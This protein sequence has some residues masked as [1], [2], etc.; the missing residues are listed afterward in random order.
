ML[1]G[2]E[3]AT[4]SI[5]IFTKERYKVAASFPYYPLNIVILNKPFRSERWN[6]EV[7]DLFIESVSKANFPQEYRLIPF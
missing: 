2:N 6:G 5:K 1:L 3:A 7:K 4:F